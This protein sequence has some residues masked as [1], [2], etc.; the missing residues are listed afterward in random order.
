[1]KAGRS[2]ASASTTTARSSVSD[3]ADMAGLDERP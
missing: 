3:E 2:S 1:M